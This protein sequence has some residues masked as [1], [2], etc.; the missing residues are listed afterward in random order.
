M[1]TNLVH[2][3]VEAGLDRESWQLTMSLRSYLTTRGHWRDLASMYR[4]AVGSADRL[5]DPVAQVRACR[6]L[7][8]A[9]TKLSEW[10]EAET[11]LLRA[12]NV[13]EEIGDLVQKAHCHEALSTMCSARGWHRRAVQHATGTRKIGPGDNPFWAATSWVRQ[14]Q[15]YAAL[16]M[17]DEARSCAVK[18]LELHR[19][20]SPQHETGQAKA[21]FCVAYV[22]SRQGEPVRALECAEEAL[23]IHRRFGNWARMVEDLELIADVHRA[24]GRPDDALAAM[25]E[26]L[27]IRE[28][29]NQPSNV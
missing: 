24:L 27:A 22:Y 2:H 1:L 21:L 8:R 7:G 14:A 17:F 9:L 20:V 18:G 28:A 12:L 16:D 23:A 13:A 25:E 15:C 11:V 19:S 4:T 6:G 3:A 5:G 10:E 29:L 26:A